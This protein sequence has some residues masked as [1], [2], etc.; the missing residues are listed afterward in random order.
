M[1]ENITELVFILDRSGS[2][3]GLE[4]DTIGGYNAVL[5]K[6]RAAE[7]QAFVTTILF[8]NEI[9]T[10]H[11]RIEL[12]KVADLT[13]KDYWVRG[14]TALLDAVGSTI[15]HIE[16]VQG[17]LPE[18]HKPG[19]TIFVITT[20][21]YENASRKF[22]RAQV[23]EMIQGKK[24]AGW[25]FLFLGANIDAVAEAGSLGIDADRAVT[26]VAD[27]QGTDVMY[28]AVAEATVCMR[29]MPAPVPGSGGKRMGGKW[30]K[31]VEADTA[32]RGGHK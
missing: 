6:H 18:D 4:S 23:K 16:K 20:D 29:S 15:R 22:S 8:D 21:G 24:N 14:C 11:D 27:E 12:A 7:G 3:G 25:E 17:Y 19:H 31:S 9:E 10:L 26:Y 28:G 5:A 2:M 1:N 32:A 13:A 30:K